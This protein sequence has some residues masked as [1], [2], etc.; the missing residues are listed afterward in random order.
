MGVNKYRRERYYG[1]CIFI[2]STPYPFRILPM[3]NVLFPIMIY[4][5]VYGPLSLVSTQSRWLSVWWN[6]TIHYPLQMAV[7]TFKHMI[8]IGTTLPSEREPQRRRNVEQVLK[9][10]LEDTSYTSWLLIDIWSLDRGHTE[11]SIFERKLKGLRR[12]ENLA[13]ALKVVFRSEGDG[14]DSDI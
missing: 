9:I 3:I 1:S 10:K 14:C 4:V 13:I 8:M 7:G 12:D 6:L 5:A 2:L 11:L